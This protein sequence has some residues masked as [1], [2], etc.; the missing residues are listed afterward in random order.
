MNAAL[1]MTPPRHLHGTRDAFGARGEQPA[2]AV[3]PASRRA[4]R[5]TRPANTENNR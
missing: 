5:T 3:M 4:I 1:S 2:N